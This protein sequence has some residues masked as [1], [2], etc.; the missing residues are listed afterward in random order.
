MREKVTASFLFRNRK[1]SYPRSV[2]H[3]FQGDYVRLRQNTQWRRMVAETVDNYVVFADIVSKISR[4]SGRLVPV[5]FV[6]TTSSMMLLD[7]RTLHVKYRVPASD[8]VRIS[9]SPYLDDIAVFH[10]KSVGYALLSTVPRFEL[11]NEF[12]RPVRFVR[13]GP[14]CTE[15]SGLSVPGGTERISIRSSRVQHA[16]GRFGP[17]DV[18]RH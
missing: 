13:G 17:A 9:L 4:S 6:V 14:K 15:P 7:Q 10:V 18:S 11:I 3:P 12:A 8:V 5:L 2:G 1:D 16:Q